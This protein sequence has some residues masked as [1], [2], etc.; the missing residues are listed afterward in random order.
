MVIAVWFVVVD[1]LESEISAGAFA[2]RR[3][4]SGNS[5]SLIF[6]RKRGTRTRSLENAGGARSTGSAGNL[7]CV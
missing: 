3:S 1:G 5:I 4:L 7:R 2:E 6:L